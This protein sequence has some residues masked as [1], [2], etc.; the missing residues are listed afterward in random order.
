MAP[1]NNIKNLKSS[2]SNS[3]KKQRLLLKISSRRH[4][5]KNEIQV[6][7][8][9]IVLKRN[10]HI[11]EQVCYCDLQSVFDIL[12]ILCIVEMS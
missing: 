10:R 2:H 3:F 11:S 6:L 1:M 4:V 5:G 8:N 9:E 12:Y 7:K